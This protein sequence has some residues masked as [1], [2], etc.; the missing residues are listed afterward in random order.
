MRVFVAVALDAAIR[1]ALKWWVT[2]ARQIVEPARVTWVKPDVAH[3][4]LHFLGEI[5]PADA[6]ALAGRLS[7]PYATPPFELSLGGPG[8]FPGVER[9]RVLWL[10]IVDCAGPLQA[11][12][13]EAG[14]R[15][16]EAGF[17]LEPRAFT[18][19]VT[20]ARVRGPLPGK[21][22]RRLMVTEGPPARGRVEA[23]TLFES[24]TGPGGSVYTPLATGRCG[25]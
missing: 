21:A 22:V 12:H 11:L 4:T 17:R 13:R 2:R 3:V 20:L 24:R 7:R 10:G 9:P 18:P 6:D 8:V 16:Q 25:G 15:L 14:E 5:E 1:D 23:V 19:H